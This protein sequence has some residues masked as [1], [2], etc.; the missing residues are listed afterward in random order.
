MFKHVLPTGPS[1]VPLRVYR[2]DPEGEEHLKCK[3]RPQ[4]W[5]VKCQ[6]NRQNHDDDYNLQEPR[7]WDVVRAPQ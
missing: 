1:R 2:Q 4:P 3:D 5:T 6:R 7:E